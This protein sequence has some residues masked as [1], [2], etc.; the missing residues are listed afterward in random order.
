MA[1][2][3]LWGCKDMDIQRVLVPILNFIDLK[4]NI[5]FWI[6]IYLTCSDLSLE[7]PPTLCE[8]LSSAIRS[9]LGD[10]NSTIQIVIRK[11]V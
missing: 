5:Y 6:R 10:P 1:Y 9:P 2:V 7:T 11:L 4:K 8:S 3:T